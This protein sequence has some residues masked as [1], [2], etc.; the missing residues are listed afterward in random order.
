V[1]V[2]TGS[3]RLFVDSMFNLTTAPAWAELTGLPTTQALTFHAVVAD[4]SNGAVYVGTSAGVLKSAN[5]CATAHNG[6]IACW[7][8]TWAPWGNGM[9]W[10]APK[11]ASVGLGNGIDVQAL[12]GQ[13]RVAANNAP[14]FYVY[15]ATWTR[16]IWVRESIGDDP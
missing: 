16:G 14:H 3:G 15:A 2:L 7:P 1:Y 6:G 10:S 4:P 8:T 9:P 5:S 12:D 13:L 11:I